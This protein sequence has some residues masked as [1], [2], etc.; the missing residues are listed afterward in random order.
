MNTIKM[1]TS[2]PFWIKIGLFFRLNSSNNISVPTVGRQVN[3]PDDELLTLLYKMILLK[4]KGNDRFPSSSFFK[5]N[6]YFMQNNYK[7]HSSSLKERC[8]LFM[9]LFLFGIDVWNIDFDH[10]KCERGHG[11][12]NNALSKE[13]SRKTTYGTVLAIISIIIIIIIIEMVTAN[14]AYLVNQ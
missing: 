14:C 4:M 6:T 7:I 5:W 2:S 3:D 9:F 11:H 1:N 13:K 12:V 8:C 10:H